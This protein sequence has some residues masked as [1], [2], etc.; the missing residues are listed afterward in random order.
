MNKEGYRLAE[1]TFEK[2]S[3]SPLNSPKKIIIPAK[4]SF[5]NLASRNGGL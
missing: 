1:R 2:I 5:K 3:D 4:R